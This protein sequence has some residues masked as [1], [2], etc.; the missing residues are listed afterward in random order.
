M[1]D[2]SFLKNLSEV[3]KLGTLLILTIIYIIVA[4][5]F[6]ASFTPYDPYDSYFLRSMSFYSIVMVFSSVLLA[7]GIIGLQ[8][9]Y[10]NG[11]NVFL[12][13]VSNV[14]G[15]V[16]IIIMTLVNILIFFM[17][18][19]GTVF[20]D[21]IVYPINFEYLY[22]EGVVSFVAVFSMI[23]IPIISILL[24]LIIAYRYHNHR[25]LKA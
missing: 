3:Q 24:F 25:L 6:L 11:T 22:A 15:S 4:I 17:P 23:L 19:T 20:M 12:T 8:Q 2:K 21:Q 18:K 9:K 13:H 10:Y 7:L 1:K 16:I 14:I 5:Y